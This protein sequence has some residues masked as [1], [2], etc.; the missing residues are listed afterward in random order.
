MYTCGH[1]Y[2]YVYV[3]E[4][5]CVYVYARVYENSMRTHLLHHSGMSNDIRTIT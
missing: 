1:I 2:T 5:V 4:Y 3:Y